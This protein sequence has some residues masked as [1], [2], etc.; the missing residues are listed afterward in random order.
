MIQPAVCP[1]ACRGVLPEH[2][3]FSHGAVTSDR[4][5]TCRLSGCPQ[6]DYPKHS[7]LSSHTGLVI[8]SGRRF[9]HSKWWPDLTIRPNSRAQKERCN[10]LVILSAPQIQRNCLSPGH[11]AAPSPSASTAVVHLN[12]PLKASLHVRPGL[13]NRSQATPYRLRLLRKVITLFGTYNP[14][15]TQTGWT[16]EFQSTVRDP[17]SPATNPFA[18]KFYNI[19]WIHHRRAGPP[20]R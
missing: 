14:L 19:A 15:W 12:W 5:L 4:T 6:A 13:H 3:P 10:A 8:L 17:V 16:K 11:P 7:P 2:R 20:G 1:S 18:D 9:R